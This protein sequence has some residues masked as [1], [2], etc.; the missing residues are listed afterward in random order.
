M[1]IVFIASEMVPFAKTG[2]LADVLGALPHEIAAL[3]HEVKLILPRYRG[4]DL[5]NFPMKKAMENFEVS[6]GAER[7]KV[8]V[9]S[10]LL[11]ANGS[12]VEVFFVEH[13]AFFER[14]G[15][16]GT[17]LGDFQDNDRR[18][19]FFSKA[20]IEILKRMDEEPDVIHCHDWQT[21]LIPAYLK[22]MHQR[23][24]LFEKARTF[25]TIH[26]LAY[27][28]NFPPDTLALTGF[29]WE[30]FTL[31]RLE[32]YGKLSFMKAGLV[33]ADI[34]TTVS[35]T[36]AHE[37]Q[38]HEF[39]CGMEGILRDRSSD[40]YGILNGIDTK[41]W[42]PETDK[43]LAANYTS[44][45]LAKKLI[46][47]GMLQKETHL[48]VDPEIPLLGMVTRL[49]DQKGLD[50]VIMVLDELA[51]RNMQFII[52]GTG[53]SK[54][55]S[56]FQSLG[57]KHHGRF[58]FNL[59]FDEKLSRRIYAGSDFFLMPSV[60]EPCGLGQMIALRYGALPIVRDVGGLTD[61][62][63]DYHENHGKGNGFVFEDKTP[64]ALLAKIDEAVTVFRDKKLWMDLQKNAMKCDFSWKASAKHYVELYLRAKRR[65]VLR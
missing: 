48:K 43:A 10:H 31:H 26:N 17:S 55:H 2:G 29:G 65:T 24:G 56:A 60:F 35:S 9:K 1:R 57:R 20:A 44:T 38:T 7:E 42:D 27:Q 21:G 64:N 6:L 19:I 49:V 15:I 12:N 16:Y 8:S 45:S 5:Q 18:F 28:G 50:L 62:V 46:N 37:I 61:T 22:L 25:F 13:P 11:A 4:M 3:G 58:S 36:Y 39:G 32:Y 23:Q 51:K 30:E 34:L 40:L 14:E 53:D 59:K 33:Y 47:K 41:E 52:I 63:T 54:Y